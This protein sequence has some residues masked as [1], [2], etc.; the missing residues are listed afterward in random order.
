ML[1]WDYKWY[2]IIKKLLE[3]T[4][5]MSEQ[6]KISHLNK[7]LHHITWHIKTYLAEIFT[8]DPKLI[9]IYWDIKPPQ[10]LSNK[11]EDTKIVEPNNYPVPRTAEELDIIRERNK[12][13]I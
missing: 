2:D 1:E 12:K 10:D 4:S 7:N 9:L 11:K 5:T 8:I 13:N 6:E 3:E